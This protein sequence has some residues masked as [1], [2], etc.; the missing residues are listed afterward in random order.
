MTFRILY[1][2][3][4]DAA[5]WQSLVDRL[6]HERRDVLLTPAYARVQAATGDGKPLCMVWEW[7]ETFVMQPALLR[8]EEGCRDLT[9]FYGGGGPIANTVVL[10]PK[11]IDIMS[12]ASAQWR[13]N[14][15]VVCEY[16]QIVGRHLLGSQHVKN[17][18]V[19]SLNH[20][21]LLS[22]FSRNRRREI[23]AAAGNGITAAAVTPDGNSISR[24]HA[25]YRESM[26]RIGA[27]ERWWYSED[28]FWSYVQHLWPEHMSLIAAGPGPGNNDPESMLL[29]VHGYGKCYAHFLGGHKHNALLYY[30]AMRHARTIG[31]ETCFLGGGT[32]D[33]TDDPLLQYKLGFSKQTVPVYV[34]KQIFDTTAYREACH[35]AGIDM[36]VEQTWFPAYRAREA[37]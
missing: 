28:V 19:V 37:A 9:S 13:E 31:C 12:R 21:Q 33:K 32:T 10:G 29:L 1:P 18:V 15:H 6:P 2:S 5:L 36:A 25:L 11:A 22:W 34:H 16:T 20:D 23:E 4:R 35:K 8:G 24:F 27:D 3:G 7:G 14:A 26:Q 30:E 17:A